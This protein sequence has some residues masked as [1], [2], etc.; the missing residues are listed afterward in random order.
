MLPQKLI[1]SRANKKLQDLSLRSNIP[2]SILMPDGNRHELGN[3]ANVTIHV[4]DIKALQS[5]AN[6]GLDTLA[7]AYI[8]GWLDVEGSI[9]DIVDHAVSLSKAAIKPN[10]A[11]Q[12]LARLTPKGRHSKKEDAQSIQYHYDVSNEFYSHWLGPT[13][14]YSCA[15]FEDGNETLEEAQIKKID[16]ILKKIMVKPGERLLDIGCGWGALAIRAAQQFGAKVVGITLSK[17]QFELASDRVRQAGL[18]NE[19]EIRLQDYRNVT[20]VFDKVTSV[21][22]FEHVGLKNLKPYFSIIKSRLKPGG[23]AMNH[24]ITSTDIH[25]GETP[26]GGGA[27]IDQYVFPNGEL[28]HISTVLRE[29]E[30]AGLET[31]DVEN[32]R[33]HYAQT[34]TEWSNRFEQSIELLATLV[35]EKTLRIWR[36][37]LPGV[38]WAFRE[39]WISLNQVLVCHAGP[40]N[41]NPTPLNRRYIYD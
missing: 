17:Q 21:G 15:Y 38:A 28:P 18:Q 23:L 30:A 39:N 13:M 3:R 14:V 7:K 35:P 6:P 4:K 29:I 36:V 10:G 31:L 16:H 24:G 5:L 1:L 9:Q 40:Q 34:A 27:F 20:E 41:L 11:N 25:N 19:I 32:L 37:Y 2:L 26:L 12:E 8:E 22:M 33:R